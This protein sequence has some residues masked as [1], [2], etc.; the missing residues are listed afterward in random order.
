MLLNSRLAPVGL[1]V[2]LLLG[3][4]SGSPSPA[5]D[6]R[7]LK[8]VPAPQPRTGCRLSGSVYD[9]QGDKTTYMFECSAPDPT[10]GRTSYTQTVAGRG[11]GPSGAL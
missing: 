5:K 4:L 9:H 6:P 1:V 8:M 2:G 10:T 7:N 3:A 11:V